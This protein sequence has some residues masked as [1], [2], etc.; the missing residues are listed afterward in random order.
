MNDNIL[1][2]NEYGSHVTDSIRHGDNDEEKD[3]S[4]FRF[5]MPVYFHSILGNSPVSCR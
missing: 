2:I 1:V 5:A 3:S 4:T